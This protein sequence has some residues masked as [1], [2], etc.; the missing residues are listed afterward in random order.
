MV[1]GTTR[2]RG[3]TCNTNAHSSKCVAIAAVAREAT[4]SRAGYENGSI[5]QPGTDTTCG[6]P[7]ATVRTLC[8][9]SRWQGE[10]HGKLHSEASPRTEVRAQHVA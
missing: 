4:Q 1:R 9:T 3:T 6:A 7:T 10:Y 8:G 5:V 2:R